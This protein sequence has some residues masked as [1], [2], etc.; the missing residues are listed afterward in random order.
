LVFARLAGTE[1]TLSSTEAGALIRYTTDGGEPDTTSSCFENPISIVEAITIN[2]KS[3]APNRLPSDTATHQYTIITEFGSLSGRVETI[4]TDLGLSG[5]NVSVYKNEAFVKDTL[6]GTDGTFIVAELPAGSGYKIVF[7]KE[8]FLPV[9]YVGITVSGNHTTYLETVEMQP[10]AAQTGDISGYVSNALDNQGVGNLRIDFRM[11]LNVTTGSVVQ[12]VVTNSDGSYS[13]S[14]LQPESYTG[15]VSGEGY[16]TT[17][18]TAVCVADSTTAGQNAT[19]TLVLPE[20]F[21]V[22]P[23][24]ETVVA[25][26]YT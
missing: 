14:D 26:S 8:G 18:F 2:T 22:Q 4:S 19:I 11:G 15:E 20:M 17:S 12:T 25:G 7:S 23:D 5:V 10:E 21:H 1:V 16:T 6:T 24:G 3:F 9:S 13:V